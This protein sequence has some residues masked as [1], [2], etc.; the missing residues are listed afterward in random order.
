MSR[1]NS[2]SYQ[3]LCSQLPQ[4]PA[5]WLVTGGAG[6]IGSHL[7]EKLLGLKQRVV[8]VDNFSTG[9]RANL[10]A[11]EKAVGEDAAK[12][13]TV[14]EGDLRDIE[15]CR[16]V[17]EGVEYILHQAALGSVPR[18]IDDPLASHANNVTAT[19]NLFTAAKDAGIRR[20]VYASSSSVYGDEATLPKVEVK[21]GA[22]LSPYAATKAICET[23]AGVFARCYGLETI[24]LR[25]FNVF[26]PRQDPDG[27]YAAVIPKW[28]QTMLS[29]DA[30]TI[31]GDGTTSRDFTYVA[32]AVQANLLAATVKSPE[33]INRAYN[34]AVGARCDLNELACQLNK[35]LAAIRPELNTAVPIHGDFRPGDIKHSLADIS[36]AEKLLGYQPEV[37]HSTGF[38]ETISWFVSSA[39]DDSAV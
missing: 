14:V 31:N 12:N 33:A 1:S 23:Y 34:V 29:G 24:G 32:N 16:Q 3:T 17:C 15:T 19:L 22:L 21:T 6:F 35:G 36:A 8:V 27:P 39:T 18:S 10:E 5:K 37:D 28:I 9:Y 26:G 2:S 7:V 11:V 30:V 13:L 4:Q 25:Y 38:Q 20:I